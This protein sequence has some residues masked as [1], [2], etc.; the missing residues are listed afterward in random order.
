MRKYNAENERAKRR[1]DLALHRSIWLR[2][3]DSI[4]IPAIVMVATDPYS[5]VSLPGSTP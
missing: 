4:N 5:R 2:L 1:Y 3:W